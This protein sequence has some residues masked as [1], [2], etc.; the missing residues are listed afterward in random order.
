M[1]LFQIHDLELAVAG[2]VVM[3]RAGATVACAG[4][5]AAIAWVLVLA[6]GI[7]TF[8]DIFTGGLGVAAVLV[9]ILVLGRYLH[10]QCFDMAPMIRRARVVPMLIGIQ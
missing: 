5:A 7:V 2:G 4:G 1:M 8:V 3:A 6:I 9:A 10:K